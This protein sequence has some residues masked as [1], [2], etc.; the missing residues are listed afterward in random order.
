MREGQ[1]VTGSQATGASLKASGQHSTE[2]EDAHYVAAPVRD[3]A[4]GDRVRLSSFGSVGIV[5]SVKG[6][7]AEVRVKS[8]RLREKLE[9]LE[10][11]EVVAPVKSSG[12]FSKLRNTRGPQVQLSTSD[13]HTQSELNVIGQRADEAVEAVDKFLD[14]ASL[15]RHQSATHRSRSWHRRASARHR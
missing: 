13:T 11:V 1:F 4:V 7:E 14:A 9:N 8:L 3:I 2:S 15:C 6:D 12:R 10:L 5:D